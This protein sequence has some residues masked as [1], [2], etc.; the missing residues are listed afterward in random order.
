MEEEKK[1]KTIIEPL[2][3]IEHLS[4]ITKRNQKSPW[5]LI[6]PIFLPIFIVIFLMQIL[7]NTID[8]QVNNILTIILLPMLAMAFYYITRKYIVESGLVIDRYSWVT[9]Y[10]GR[11]GM[12]LYRL[13]NLPSYENFIEACNISLRK[14]L[15]YTAIDYR[16]DKSG[17]KRLLLELRTRL[18]SLPKFVNDN[19]TNSVKMFDMGKKFMDLGQNISLKNPEIRIEAKYLQQLIDFLPEAK[20]GILLVTWNALTNKVVIGF[21]VLLVGIATGV[22]SYVSLHFSLLNSI[23]VALG[24]IPVITSI[25]AILTRK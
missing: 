8:K 7:T 17:K 6:I 19:K 21:L 15:L 1:K 13:G 16:G 3:Y 11:I 20:P 5:E 22:I 18:K 4:L 25:Y 12:E 2:W 24:I 9:F 10:S 14:W 23:L